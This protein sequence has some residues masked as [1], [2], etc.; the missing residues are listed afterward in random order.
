MGKKDKMAR[1]D[2]RGDL[3]S[4]KQRK[5]LEAREAELAA[6]LAR[7]EAKAAKKASKK[8]KGKK[9]GKPVETVA[10]VD[11]PSELKP[12]R[13]TVATALA[14]VKA[15][16]AK[17][18][19]ATVEAAA[20]EALATPGSEG[21]HIAAATAKAAATEASDDDTDEQIKARVKGKRDRRAELAAAFDSIDRDD[22]AAV[23]AYNDELASL[24]GG[25]FATSNATKAATSAK[26]MAKD[27]NGRPAF[28]MTEEG[29]VVPHP[30][31][32][33]AQ[34]IVDKFN[35][36][37]AMIDS[38]TGGALTEHVERSREAAQVVE[39]VET[40]RG[41]IY[42]A[43][44]VDNDDHDLVASGEIILAD[45]FAKPSEA[46]KADFDTNGNGQYLVKRPSD[47]K[48]VGYT[49]A[50]TYIACLED[51]SM[52]TKWKMRVLLEGVAINDTP[53]DRGD[54]AGDP[55]VG[56]M[57]DLIHRRDVTI[58]KALKQDRKGKLGIGELASHVN[59]AWADYKKAV[60][61][62][63]DDL[64]EVG[65]AH[66]KAQK[67]TDLHEYTEVL[68]RHGIDAVG[69]LLEEGA[70]A[71]ADFA[72]VVAYRDALDAAGIK[73]VTEHIEQVV[74]NHDLKVAGRLDRV[75]M[76]KFPGAQRA[77]R[78]VLDLKTGRVDLG[79]GKIA[80]Q[81]DVY[82]N[83]KGYDLNTHEEVDLKLN[84]TKAIL[85]H[86]PAGSAKATVHVVDLTAGHKANALAAQVRA[87]R[88]EGKRAID[89]K[90]DLATAVSE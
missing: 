79:V 76:V 48:L 82:A 90:T 29:D 5:A 71:P 36:Q 67:G 40:E 14:D 74:V 73:I 70:I 57:R 7:R 23:K 12:E 50:T 58:A 83:A 61:K 51:T 33:A 20:D 59:G 26:L 17:S 4:K 18:P 68:D 78:C 60:N 64:L 16:K 87:W 55:V 49:R 24:G 3:L 27:A 31:A 54:F 86:L 8:S 38:A 89:L 85:V 46:P 47:G 75:A 66:E 56:V 35:E 9:K 28:A 69:K 43:G 42:Q 62:I 72:D 45:D 30:A 37:Y 19:K 25:K 32:E 22:E 77:V 39:P 15:K 11:V 80:Q 6:E 63:A 52:L 41:T 2:E 13:A 53:T 10:V 65:G 44:S 34:V 21:A 1:A 81:L 84:R 88:N